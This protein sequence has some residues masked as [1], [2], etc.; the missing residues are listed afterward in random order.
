MRRAVGKPRAGGIWVAGLSVQLFGEIMNMV[1]YMFCAASVVVRKCYAFKV[2]HV[3]I[4][5]AF[6]FLYITSF[7]SLTSFVLLRGSSPLSL[8]PFM[9]PRSP[10]GVDGS[11]RIGC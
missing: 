11:H 4:T 5:C 7:C 2:A 8:G 10:L 9:Y 1:S 6:L 3:K